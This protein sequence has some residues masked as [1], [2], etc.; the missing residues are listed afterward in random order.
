MVGGVYDSATKKTTFTHGTNSCD[1]DWHSQQS[2]WSGS[3]RRTPHAVGFWYED[4]PGVSNSKPYALSQDLE[5]VVN[6]TSFKVSGDWSNAT[7]YVGY[8]YLS[9]IHISE[10]TRPY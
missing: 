1:F 3:T 10:P 7:I 6:G 4:N 8:T 9:L 2:P 5:D